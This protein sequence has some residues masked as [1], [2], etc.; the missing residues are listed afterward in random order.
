MAALKMIG[1][2]ETESGDS[3]PGDVIG[4]KRLDKIYQVKTDNVILTCQAV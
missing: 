3:W 1:L 2:L 4:N